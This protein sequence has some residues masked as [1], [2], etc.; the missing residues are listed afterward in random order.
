MFG[1]G[2]RT[3]WQHGNRAGNRQSAGIP[4]VTGTSVDLHS[5]LRPRM[6]DGSSSLPVSGRRA[7]HEIVRLVMVLL[8][9]LGG[10]GMVLYL[11]TWVIVPVEDT[12]VAA[13]GAGP[14]RR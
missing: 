3:I 7:G 14:G 1:P 2:P 13:A 5:Y 9:L 6:C 12:A 4:S 11:V 8:S 10:R